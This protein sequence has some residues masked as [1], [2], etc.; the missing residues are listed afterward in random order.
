MLFRRGT[1]EAEKK[2]VKPCVHEPF[3]ILR[4]QEKPIGE[5]D[6][7]RLFLIYVSDQIKYVCTQERL[8]ASERED[9]NPE[10]LARVD[11]VLGLIG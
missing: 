8:S 2:G 5:Q 1:I 6:G 4:C 3:N 10:I 11:K 9:A 7:H